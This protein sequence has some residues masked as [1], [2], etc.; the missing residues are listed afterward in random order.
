MKRDYVRFILLMVKRL[1]ELAEQTPGH[2]RRTERQWETLLKE[3][4][5][6]RSA[7]VGGRPRKPRSTGTQSEPA[8][9]FVL[10]GPHAD[11]V[12]QYFSVPGG[13]RD[14]QSELSMLTS[15]VTDHSAS[16]PAY[17]YLQG[18]PFS[19][20][21]S[22]LA[23]FVQSGMPAD[24]DVVGYFIATRLGNNRHDL[25]LKTMTAQLA[26][27][28][29]QKPP[30]RSGSLSRDQ[31]HELCQVAASASKARGRILLVVVD[32]LDEDEGAEPGGCSIAGY[33]PPCP[34]A[35][36][37]ILVSGRP[38]P[39]PPDD[40]PPG[41]PLALATTRRILRAWPGA[42]TALSV[43][44][45]ELL[46][47]LKDRPLGMGIVG[48]ITAARRGLSARDLSKLLNV[49]PLDIN[50]R[51]LS[52]KGRSF[53]FDHTMP[54]AARTYVLAH[55]VFYDAVLAQL[56]E[57]SPYEQQLHDWADDHRE[58][59][60]PPDTSAYLLRHYTAGL[61]HTPEHAH[62]LTSFALDR[63]RQRRL[64]DEAA[65]D[66]VVADLDQVA[67]TVTGS[68]PADLEILAEVAASRSLIAVKARPLPRSVPETFAL[69]GDAHRARSLALASRCPAAKASVLAGVARSLASAG[70]PDAGDAAR[71][72][73]RWVGTALWGADPAS[74][75]G[76][77]CEAAAAETAVALIESG[78]AMR[79]G[80]LLRTAGCGPFG[81]I[82]A[83]LS[84]QPHDA[85]VKDEL[86]D[87]A[88]SRAEHMWGGYFEGAGATAV[89]AWADI[90]RADPDRAERLYS[91]ISEHVSASGAG[92]EG[93]AVAASA[94]A[95]ARPAQAALFAE[96]AHAAISDTLR[97]SDGVPD[98]WQFPYTLDLV[99][100]ALRG[101]GGECLADQLLKSVPP[102]LLAS[103]VGPDFSLSEPA[104]R[105]GSAVEH[106]A[107]DAFALAE[108]GMGSE[109]RKLLDEAL[110]RHAAGERPSG[111]GQLRWP[112]VLA[113]ALM[114]VDPVDGGEG[115]SRQGTDSPTEG[116]VREPA[117]DIRA[118][119][120][121]LHEPSEQVRVFAFASLGVSAT[122]RSGSGARLAHAAAHAARALP[123]S[124]EAATLQALAAQA[125]AHAGDSEAAEEL[126]RG[127]AT[128]GTGRR[129]RREEARRGQL[130]VLAG[131]GTHVPDE[132]SRKIDAAGEQI[133]ATAAALGPGLA[134]PLPQLA[135][136]LAAV[137]ASVPGCRNRLLDAIC[138]AEPSASEP[139]GRWLPENDL[140]LALLQPGR[141]AEQRAAVLE[142]LDRSQRYAWQIDPDLAT[143]VGFALV[144]AALGDLEGARQA[145]ERLGVPAMQAEAYAVVAG[146]L[147]RLPAHLPTGYDQ[148][149][150]YPY[151]PVLRSLA[152]TSASTPPEPSDI[153]AARAFARD[154]LTADDG[155]YHALPVL[156][157]LSPEAVLRVR[158]VLFDH[159]QDAG[160]ER[161]SG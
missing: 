156:A 110:Q 53:S 13:L 56:G 58:R 51:L 36:L 66:V 3:A 136:L 90:A 52:L 84:C 26:A 25:F 15:F 59:L 46:D 148:L 39:P 48:L 117:A 11:L 6:E 101:T 144:R 138:A 22:L 88:E 9:D 154:A 137:P 86:L 19:G 105:D 60:W 139:P 142:R 74:M 40:V 1:E 20:K 78:Q 155:W 80:A 79:A 18:A 24:V 75:D 143:F 93:W 130:A 150:R 98:V 42:E 92:P 111:S 141:T 96:R 16:A 85:A 72:A 123:D 152:G 161:F 69:L 14:R 106:L 87:E 33:L 102:E 115:A 127:A 118:L 116:V 61:L 45:R 149:P 135:E 126:L 64:L 89:D 145:V 62:R 57:L 160:D 125:L 8:P 140:V 65:G 94:L 7:N 70:H 49:L 95:S 68:S 44:T 107:Q 112:V 2:R 129:T 120:D 99:V 104:D 31:F 81:F 28:A 132:A 91:R 121:S 147:A 29:G 38:N 41:H 109:A 113:G 114:I 10:P 122:G 97:A 100:R 55:K 27:V 23:H 134:N 21:S 131:L 32:G 73:E 77:A 37:R 133:L 158:D 5:A 43:A 63:H 108:R 71:E 103:P 35:N 151:L 82:T 12:R 50:E 54:E 153:R 47:L 30:A 17:L 146:L 67:R 119:A 128:A 124:R 83:A 34:P 76:E 157:L 4:Q 159:W